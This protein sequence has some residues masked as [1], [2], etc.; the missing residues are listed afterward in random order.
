MK[1]ALVV[2]NGMVVGSSVRVPWW[3][4]TKTVLAVGV[5][6]L[7]RDR[8][9]GLD[10]PLDGHPF[11][12]RQLLQHRSG[13]PDYGQRADYQQ[14]V[15][16]GDTPWPAAELLRRS[17]A[18][19]LL[20]EPDADFT[21][22]NVGYLLLRQLVE[23]V[24]D[25]PL[26]EALETLILGPLGIR[27]VRLLDSGEPADGVVGLRPGYD[28]GWVYHGL[29]AGPLDQA[30]LL[31]HRLI[32]GDLL[33]PELLLEM[34]RG[35]HVAGPIPGRPF[36]NPAYGLGLMIEDAAPR[37]L[38]HTGGGPDSRIAVYHSPG[39]TSSAAVFTADVVDT[40][41]G[42]LERRAFVL[43]ADLMG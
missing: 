23:R 31:L 18:G 15:A 24:A 14:A 20:F 2:E 6:V 21:Y 29:L 30:A 36:S 22:S 25:R 10:T 42:D 3:S 7:A 13:L 28:P 5:L 37:W 33:P 26:G 8:R 27:D 38:G 16:A 4:F 1:E 39:T 35:R 11:T 43:V 17:E 34:R 41:D 32:V 12:P 9:L 40:T 19:R